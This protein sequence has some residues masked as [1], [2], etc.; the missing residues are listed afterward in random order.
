M[1]P[2]TAYRV[3]RRKRGE[4]SALNARQH[5]IDMISVAAQKAA[6]KGVEVTIEYSEFTVDGKIEATVTASPPKERK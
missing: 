1:G 3:G 2:A 4:M 5:V 6:D